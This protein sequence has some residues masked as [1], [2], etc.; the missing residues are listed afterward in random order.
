M[1]ATGLVA[2]GWSPDAARLTA[3][4]LAIT[5]GLSLLAASILP[6]LAAWLPSAVL[7]AVTLLYGSVT[8]AGYSRQ[9]AYLIHPVGST[10][11]NIVA[12]TVFLAGAGGYVLRD[13]QPSTS[14]P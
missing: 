4:N 3:R 5:G 13:A 7:V 1:S 2:L 10:A 12:V 8:M 14:S 11:A 9:F 6:P